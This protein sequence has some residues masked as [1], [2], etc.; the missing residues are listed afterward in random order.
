MGGIAYSYLRFSTPEQSKGDSR[1]RQAAMAEGYATRHGLHLDAALNFRDLG[2]SAF[3]SKN[4]R[5]GGLRDF[6]SAVEFGLVPPESTLLIE[7]LD[8]LSRAEVLEAQALFLQIIN[9]GIT[10][11]TLIDERSYSKISLNLNPIDLL[12][13]L[14]I[15]MRAN[16]ESATKSKRLRAAVAS[17]RE[18]PNSRYHGAQCPAW[19]KPKSSKDGYEIIP[20]RTAIIR[21]IFSEAMAG[22]G[23]QSITR[24][25]NA[26]GTPMFGRGNQRGKLWQR[27]LIRH[28]LYTPTVIGEYLPH[29]GEM[30]NGQLRFVP[31]VTKHGYY[32]AVI[33]RADW[34][35][36]QQRRR[37]WSRHYKC[38]ARSTTLV[39][40]VI[41]RLA[42]CPRCGRP[43]VLVRDDHPNHKYLVCMAWREAKRCSNEWVRYPEIEDVFIFEIDHLI[44]ACPEPILSPASRKARLK[45]ISGKLSNLRQRLTSE[46]LAHQALAQSGRTG[47]LWSDETKREIDELKSERYRLRLDRNYWKDATLA[48]KLEALR[49]AVQTLPRDLA[50]VNERLRLLLFKVVV[51]W[52]NEQ[53]VLHWRHGGQT[54]RQFYRQRLR[55]SKRNETP[56]VDAAS[57]RMRRAGIWPPPPG[58]IE[59]DEIVDGDIVSV[60]L[61]ALTE[62]RMQIDRSDWERVKASYGSRWTISNDGGFVVSR[63]LGHNR[64]I[65]EPRTVVLARIVTGASPGTV[66]TYSDGDR[67][68]L[69]SANL[70]TM[71]KADFA[72]R[73]ILAPSAVNSSPPCSVAK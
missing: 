12:I 72:R 56:L 49:S 28:I 31:T 71:A 41:S 38:R 11:V 6:L 13:S 2:M 7:S 33:D 34:D 30:V 35:F 53:L 29:R 60:R 40:N 20:E 68:N 67:L 26:D 1:R 47:R 5:Q 19:L 65:N 44:S 59:P 52:E 14:I 17:N 3:R 23:L 43:M 16:D 37:A 48:L 45:I 9:A 58:E 8:R 54:N 22:R 36:L 55:G 15:M 61:A 25:L 21:R 63:R 42:K 46:E 32:P 51:D 69:R 70:L 39:A 18:D 10:I 50:L 27:A 64:P 66:V 62:T 73:T 4:A 57:P 24:D